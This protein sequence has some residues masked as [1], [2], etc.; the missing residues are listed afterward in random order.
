[1]PWK[2]NSR[3]FTPGL[4]ALIHVIPDL[5]WMKDQNGVFLFCNG[6]FE[7]L[8]GKKEREIVGKTDYDFPESGNG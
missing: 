5:V 2:Q 4:R 6:R 3:I 7:K 8:L 1:M